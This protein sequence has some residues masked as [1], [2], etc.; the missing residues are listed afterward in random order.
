MNKEEIYDEF[1]NPL[2]TEIINICKT[3]KINAIMSFD[4]RDEGNADL[5]CTTALPVDKATWLQ[6]YGEA[7]ENIFAMTTTK[8]IDDN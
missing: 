7:I 1:I 5:L 2:M 8:E 4:L 3:N 6:S